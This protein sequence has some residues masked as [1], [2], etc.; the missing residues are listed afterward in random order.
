[1]SNDVVY[2]AAV[3]AATGVQELSPDGE[4]SNAT[5]ATP[6]PASVPLP[7]SVTAPLSTAAGFVNEAV[8]RVASTR[9]AT[10]CATQ[11][12]VPPAV[13]VNGPTEDAPATAAAPCDE[14][15]PE[16]VEL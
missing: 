8:G 13:A 4:I 6:D 1:M 11:R 5:D 15:P 9:T 12:P 14:A 3:T 10:S 2:G 16:A 7:V